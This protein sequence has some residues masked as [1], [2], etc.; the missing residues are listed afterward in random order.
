MGENAKVEAQWLLS[1]FPLWELHSYESCECLKPWLERKT[2]TKL[3]PQ[4]TIRKVLKRRCLKCPRIIHL[5]L[6]CMSYDQK[7]GENQ[8]EIWLPTKS[9]ESRGQMRFDWNMLYTGWKI[10]ARAIRYFPRIFF[11]KPWFEKYMNIQSFGITKVPILGLPLGSS[12]E[13]WHLDVVPAERHRVYYREGS[14]ASSER[15]RVVWSSCMKLFLL[16]PPHHFHS[17]YTNC[18]FLLVVQVDLVLNSHLWV[19][20]SPILKLQHALLPPKCFE[21]RN[22]PQ[23]F[24][25][26][27]VLL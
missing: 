3:G 22:V 26:Y 9:L 23:L 6:I 11:K 14:G 20:P 15:L 8:M 27:V 5:D 13:K 17:T 7:M 1:A 18:L 21:L 2:S 19:H 16:S 25:S 4:D 24:S 10:F 12:K